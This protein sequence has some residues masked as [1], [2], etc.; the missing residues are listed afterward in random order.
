MARDDTKPPRT[1]PQDSQLVPPLV[2]GRAAKVVQEVGPWRDPG[3]AEPAAGLAA[4][5]DLGHPDRLFAIEAQVAQHPQASRTDGSTESLRPATLA[6]SDCEAGELAGITPGELESVACKPCT[7]LPRSAP[8]ARLA[9]TPTVVTALVHAAAR[10]ET[11]LLR[12]RNSAVRMI[13]PTYPPK[14]NEQACTPASGSSMT[15]VAGPAS[16]RLVLRAGRIRRGE[17]DLT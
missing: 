17:Q 13:T 7:D 9:V 3:G 10:G 4:E 8:S 15:N 1:R 16:R 2:P 12:N 5:G 11:R 6:A 14:G